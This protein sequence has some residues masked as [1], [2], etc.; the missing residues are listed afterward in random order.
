LRDHQCEFYCN[1]STVDRILC[2]HQILEKNGNIIRYYRHYL[3]DFE[4]TYDSVRKEVLCSILIEFGIP[5]QLVRLIRMHLNETYRNVHI[6]KY[7]MHLI[8]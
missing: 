3:I 2:I 7:L 8:F 4:K 6:G 5:M 1:K